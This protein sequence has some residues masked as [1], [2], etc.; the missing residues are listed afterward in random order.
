MIYQNVLDFIGNTPVLKL[1]NLPEDYA[2]VY[3]KLEKF[4]LAGSLKDRVAKYLIERGEESGDLTKGKIIVEASSGNMGIAT[5]LIGKI[6]GYKVIICMCESASM[7][8][9]QIL[10]AFGAEIVLTPKNEHTGG[11]IKRAKE[12]VESAPDKY[13]YPN[14]F[15]NMKN[16]EGHYRFTGE[17][18]LKDV[19]DLDACV[20]GAGS[21]G[22]IVGVGKRLKESNP[23]VKICLVEPEESAVFAGKPA[24]LHGVEGIGSGF[25]PDIFDKKI[26]DEYM[27]ANL[28]ESRKMQ[29]QMIDTQGLFL[30]ISSGAAIHAG[31]KM[32]KKLGKGKK[33]VV[34]AVDGGEKY[35]S[36]GAF[37]RD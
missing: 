23:N 29:M 8:R 33:V 14:Q 17:E 18:I 32:A 34:I 26:I 16:L 10:K 11:A 7:E 12:F 5:A 30:G 20:A 28:D 13:F 31:M 4:N 25:V 15:Q 6:K 21:S 22:T 27:T 2:E 35:L 9:R 37:D 3:V 1:R 36:T 24:G 19:P